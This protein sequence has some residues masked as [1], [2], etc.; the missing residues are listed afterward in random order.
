MTMFNVIF[1]V[2]ISGM[3]SKWLC[4]SRAVGQKE[5]EQFKKEE[6]SSLILF[7]IQNSI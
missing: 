7:P 5:Q 3:I 4:L 1:Y 2:Q 6:K